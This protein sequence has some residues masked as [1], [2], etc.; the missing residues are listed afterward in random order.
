M[1]VHLDPKL[2]AVLKEQA[3]RRGVSP[4]ELALA[5]L[6]GQLLPP[7]KLEPRDDWERGLLEA[8]RPCGVSLSNA[9]LSSDALY[10]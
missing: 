4:E 8:A 10:D 9:D 1:V 3:E 6:R 2:E 5:V 7:P